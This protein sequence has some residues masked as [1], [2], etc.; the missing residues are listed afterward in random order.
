MK[1]CGKCLKFKELNEFHIRKM[2]NDGFN[3]KCKDCNKDVASKWNKINP[4]KHRKYCISWQ[5]KNL[6]K[7]C[8]NEAYRRSVKLNA[9]PKWLTIAQLREIEQY[10]IDSAYIQQLMQ[11]EMHVDHIVPLRG[12]NV[13]GLHVPWNLQI[14]TR[15]DNQSKG[16]K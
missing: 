9:T 6:D 1:K 13:C 3:H 4:D 15:L 7:H 5:Q 11:T 14:L 10:Y 8:K 12:E 2:S 16:N